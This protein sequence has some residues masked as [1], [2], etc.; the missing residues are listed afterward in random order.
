MSKSKETWSDVERKTA[1][2]YKAFDRL[3]NTY[4]NAADRG[5]KS[6][7]IEEITTILQIAEYEQ[8]FEP[9][10]NIIGGFR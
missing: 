4:H 5:E 6:I 9:E 2:I 1:K 7:P 3:C 10:I 8:E